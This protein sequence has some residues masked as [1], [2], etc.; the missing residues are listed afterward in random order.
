MPDYAPFGFVPSYSPNI[1]DRRGPGDTTSLDHTPEWRNVPG[2][3]AEF[4]TELGNYL[5]GTPQLPEGPDT[6]LGDALGRRDI[7]IVPQINSRS[8]LDRIIDTASDEVSMFLP[9]GQKL[10]TDVPF[11]QWQFSAGSPWLNRLFGA[12]V[13]ALG[14]GNGR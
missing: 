8:P 1:E 14:G 5:W 10:G 11:T 12:G 6:P 9:P 7:R 4:S 3:L 13:G 2:T